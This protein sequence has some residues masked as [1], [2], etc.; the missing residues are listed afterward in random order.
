MGDLLQEL[1]MLSPSTLAFL[2]DVV[3]SVAA[4]VGIVLTAFLGKIWAA[5]WL[6]ARDRQD[7]EAE[8]RRHALELSKL[9]LQRKI[10]MNAFNADKPLRPSILDFLANYRD[11]Q[12][13]GQRTPKELYL[14]IDSTRITHVSL[15]RPPAE[16]V[17]P[18]AP[19]LSRRKRLAR[20]FR[21]LFQRY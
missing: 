8:W 13:L 6:S 18:A 3:K 10:A 12:E 14:K 16:P 17:P 9:D 11:L 5:S 21:E 4:L 15:P 1:D 7:R 19:R 2:G 20:A